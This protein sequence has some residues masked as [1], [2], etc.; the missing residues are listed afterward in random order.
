MPKLGVQNY[1]KQTWKNNTTTFFHFFM[2]YMTNSDVLSKKLDYHAHY[3][4]VLKAF[5]HYEGNMGNLFIN[6]EKNFQYFVKKQPSVYD[7]T[8]VSSMIQWS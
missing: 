6:Y 5:L 4:N 8:I 3:D 2:L 1:N 7:Q